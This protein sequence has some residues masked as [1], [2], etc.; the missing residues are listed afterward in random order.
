M[1]PSAR[2]LRDQLAPIAA[3]LKQGRSV[4]RPV[5]QATIRLKPIPGKDRFESTVDSILRWMNRRAGRTLPE[6]AWNR[7]S[8]ELSDV[9]AQRT[10]A[11]TLAEPRYWAARLDDADKSVPMRT[12]VTEIGVG[13]A[14]DGDTLFG[15]RL[16]CTSRGPD[17]PYVR[18]VP[19]FVREVLDAGAA[20]LDGLLVQREPRLISTDADVLVLLDLL[21]NPR[22]QT[23]VVVIALP[24]ASVDP[25]EGSVSGTDIQAR[26]LCVSHV[27]VITGPASF[28]LTRRVGKELSVFRSAVRTYRPGFRAWL[29]EPSAHPLALPHRITAWEDIGPKAFEDWLVDVALLSS[30]R[31]GDREERLPAFNNVRQLAA[32]L[33]RARIKESGGSDTELLSLYEQDNEQLRKELR[34][35][36]ELHD[37]LLAAADAERMAANEAADLA[38]AQALERAHRIRVLER[39]LA[40]LPVVAPQN[41][42]PT[43]LDDFE[44]W[45]KENLTGSVELVSRAFQGVRKSDYHD[46]S[47][48]YQVLLFLR[49]CYVPMRIEGTLERREAYLAEL[50]RLQLDDAPTGDG[51]KYAED[52]YSVQYGGSRRLLDRHLKGSNSRDRRYGF[53]LYFFWDA[54]GQ[55]VVVGWLPSHLQNRLS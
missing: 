3:K 51:V 13:A 1:S 17:E 21:E 45:C 12:W 29:A 27:F 23:D 36:S 43:R 18:T 15:V 39:R 38:R 47:Y 26:L 55:V 9:G 10:A 16:I 24:E 11:V 52:L 14:D 34:E 33:D 7:A 53:R 40:E 30:V 28:F 54:D 19:S 22:R 20:E 32:R 31:I 4:I 2:D 48:I 35:Q 5:S 44:E 49:D 50:K 6:E 46:P 42:I 41:P 37:G 25:R 8:F